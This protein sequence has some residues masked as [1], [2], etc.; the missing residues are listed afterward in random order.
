M[1]P[2]VKPAW[3][4]LPVVLYLAVA[5]PVQVWAALGGPLPRLNY[6]HGW[7]SAVAYGIGAPWVAY[8]LWRRSPRARMAAYIF[9]AFDA[10]RSL[11]LEHRLPLALDLALL[12]YLQSPPLRRF[13]PSMWSR[14]RARR[15]RAPSL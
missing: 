11:R 5:L 6:G 1:E 3:P 9:L 8:L 4:A 15:R 2:P 10:A 12:L 13:Y 7:A 14:T